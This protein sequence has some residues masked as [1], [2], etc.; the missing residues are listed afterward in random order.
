MVQQ[1]AAHIA[2]HVCAHHV[3]AVVHKHIAGSLNGQQGQHQRAQGVD[4]AQGM[5]RQ[6]GQDRPGDVAGA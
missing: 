2:F 3:P 4:L 1:L 5:G 6:A